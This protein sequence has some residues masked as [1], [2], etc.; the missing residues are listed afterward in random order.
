MSRAAIRAALASPNPPQENKHLR[1]DAGASVKNNVP[2][3]AG[4]CRDEALVPLVEA[5]YESGAQDR[6]VRPARRP[7][8]IRH[9]G[10]GGAPRAEKQDAQDGVADDV[11]CLADVEV[12]IVKAFP[13]HTKEEMQQGIEDAASIVGREQGAGF[14]GN[15]DQPEDRGDPGF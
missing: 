3:C 4:A 7:F 10:Q 5:G 14:N 8:R 12:P 11:A 2:H 15:D 1:R 9:G 13:V 6:D